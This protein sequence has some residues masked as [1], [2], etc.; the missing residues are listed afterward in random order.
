MIKEYKENE[1]KKQ[2]KLP[3]WTYPLATRVGYVTLGMSI[4]ML[5]IALKSKGVI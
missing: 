2:S 1:F 4:I 5:Y 3:S